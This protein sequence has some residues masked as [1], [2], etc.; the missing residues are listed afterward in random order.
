MKKFYSRKIEI[1]YAHLREILSGTH[2]E[3]LVNGTE[4]EKHIRF[5]NVNENP[6]FDGTP[7]YPEKDGAYR[8]EIK[9]LKINLSD[10]SSNY[11]ELDLTS[12]DHFSV[13]FIKNTFVGVAVLA[14]DHTLISNVNLKGHKIKFHQNRFINTRITLKGTTI[15]LVGNKMESQLPLSARADLS[16]IEDTSGYKLQSDINIAN[17]RFY[18]LSLFTGQGK[19]TVNLEAKNHITY[20]KSFDQDSDQYSHMNYYIGPKLILDLDETTVYLHR[21]L[22]LDLLG[23]TIEKNDKSQEK[24]VQRI[25]DRLDY[26]IFRMSNISSLQEWP[27]RFFRWVVFSV[28]LQFLDR[29]FWVRSILWAV[30]F[31]L[32]LLPPIAA[33]IVIFEFVFILPMSKN[34]SIM[35]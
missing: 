23:K 8:I 28:K 24:I 3:T 7:P 22:F 11:D 19:G 21:M 35:E 13:E 18:V 14:D 9:N 12:I 33:G 31:S 20:L 4:Y 25:I 17:N 16:C 32:L 30:A 15:S 2:D 6:R 29:H 1:S 34:F 10:I 26:Q 5:I 27:N